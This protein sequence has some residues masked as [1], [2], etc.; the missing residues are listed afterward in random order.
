MAHLPAHRATTPRE[1]IEL[2]ASAGAHRAIAAGDVPHPPA[3]GATDTAALVQRLIV[4]RFAPAAVLTNRQFEALYF[5]GPTDRFLA[6]PK[7]GPTRNL[8]S[9]AREGL[10]SRLRTAIRERRSG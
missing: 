8:L 1:L 10:R 7:G 6:Q 4:D 3:P 9:L 2:P 5:C